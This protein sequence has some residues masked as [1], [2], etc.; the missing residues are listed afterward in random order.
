MCHRCIERRWGPAGPTRTPPTPTGP[1]GELLGLS[2][3]AGTLSLAL[4]PPV[5]PGRGD[6]W[7]CRCAGDGKPPQSCQVSS[8][9]VWKDFSKR[10]PPH[11][12]V[13]V[14]AGPITVALAVKVS[15][16][17]GSLVL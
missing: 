11:P 16:P 12:W 14:F 15:P 1:L 6:S 4:W 5:T 3:M 17:V 2:H 10:V 7:G 13:L 8:D 9:A